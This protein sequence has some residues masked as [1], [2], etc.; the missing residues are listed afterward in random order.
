MSI[1][2]RSQVEQD[3]TVNEMVVGSI[4]TRGNLE[5]SSKLKNRSVYFRNNEHVKIL[6]TNLKRWTAKYFAII[7]YELEK[8]DIIVHF[9]VSIY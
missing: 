4:S 9:T 5:L 3:I 1:V 2:N 8:R 7:P 6:G